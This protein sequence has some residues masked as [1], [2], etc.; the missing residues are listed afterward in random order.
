VS[1]NSNARRAQ[2]LKDQWLD[3]LDWMRDANAAKLD[4][5]AKGLLIR[6]GTHSMAEWHLEKFFE[7]VE[8]EVRVYD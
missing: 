4:G 2:R 8:Q 5:T 7:L 6:V 1:K 3:A